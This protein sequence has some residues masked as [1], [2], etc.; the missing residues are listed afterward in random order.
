MALLGAFG[1]ATEQAGTCCSTAPEATTTKQSA[2][3]A[4]AARASYGPVLATHEG[5]SQDRKEQRD[6]KHELA[7]HCSS[8]KIPLPTR[9]G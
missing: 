1:M 3:R 8:S 7:I 2:V 4:T 9:A 6:P 5:D